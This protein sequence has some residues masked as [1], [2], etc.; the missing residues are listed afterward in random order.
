MNGYEIVGPFESHRVIVSGR[1]VPF[2]SA[3][4]VNGGKIAL[5][6]DNRIGVD[7]DVAQADALIPFIADCIAVAMGYTCHPREGDEPRRSVPFPRSQRVNLIC[8]G[9]G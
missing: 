5:T 2:L 6:L 7:V 4:P 3:R 8:G 1:R 9:T